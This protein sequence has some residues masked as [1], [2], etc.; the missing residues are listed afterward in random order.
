[1]STAALKLFLFIL[2][3]IFFFIIFYII[4]W[5]LRM[6]IVRKSTMI[7]MEAIKER[8]DSFIAAPENEFND[9]LKDFARNTSKK[10]R[11]YLGLVD[12][13]L[14][15]AI[16][17][18]TP[19]HRDRLITIARAL[20]FPSDCI[21]QIRSRIPR[22]SAQG[23]RRAGLYNF[24]E[25]IGDMVAALDVLSSENQFEILMGLA[26]I[27]KA[28]AMVTAFEKI[29]NNIIVNERAI[30]EILNIFPD[31]MEK[32]AL[33]RIML[34]H[35][36]NYLAAL[37]LKAIDREMVKGLIGGVRKI[38]SEGDK[39]IRAAAVRGLAT[40]NDKAPARDLIRTL[41][42]DDD[43][44][45]RAQ[46]AKALGAIKI[47]EASL[48]LFWALH[49]RQWWVRQNAANALTSHED[50]EI[51]FILA[52]ESGD[53]FSLDS[54]ISALENTGNTGLLDSLRNLAA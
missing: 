32:M 27:G 21:A 3:A 4:I 43:W 50:Y 40:L 45:V 28:N 31:G 17:H 8:I 38:L 25:A 20:N 18:A 7:R 46:A 15:S 13:C 35:K 5:K 51:L 6:V 16:E 33:F 11:A 19:E 10:S 2:M 9:G 30:I 12:D 14:L 54:L 23:S 52:A 41:V 26:R 1:M 36:T 48:A 47:S 24:T 22:I 42:K 39:E 44:E 37:F 49:D 34:N 29:K 53:K